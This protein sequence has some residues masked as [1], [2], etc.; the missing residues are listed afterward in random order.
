MHVTF[1]SLK[2]FYN[3]LLQ[4]KLK[5]VSD[6]KFLEWLNEENVVSPVCT[7]SGE[8]YVTHNNEIYIL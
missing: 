5:E 1:D 4:T 3:I 2:T 7:E 8:L 6:D